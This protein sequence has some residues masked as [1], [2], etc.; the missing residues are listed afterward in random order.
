MGG[1]FVEPVLL[2]V[3]LAGHVVGDFQVTYLTCLAWRKTVHDGKA[4]ELVLVAELRLLLKVLD[5]DFFSCV[6]YS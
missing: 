2:L 3:F 5:G 1:Y 4:A 6:P